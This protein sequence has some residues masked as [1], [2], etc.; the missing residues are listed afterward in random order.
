MYKMMGRPRGD[1]HPGE[2]APGA[3]YDSPPL[4]FDHTDSKAYKRG[5]SQ[6]VLS[7]DVVDISRILYALNPVRRAVFKEKGVL[8]ARTAHSLARNDKSVATIA[9]ALLHAE[10]KVV[11]SGFT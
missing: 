8:A 3:F 11:I 7:T 5:T 6:V 9:R 2:P 4:P 10:P 1:V